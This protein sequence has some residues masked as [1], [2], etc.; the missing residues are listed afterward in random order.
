VKSAALYKLG[1]VKGL[2]WFPHVI[3]LASQ[4]DH[5]APFDSAHVRLNGENN[6]GSTHLVQQKMARHILKQLRGCRTVTRADV[7]FRIEE[8]GIDALIGRTAHI[9]LIESESLIEML[10]HKYTEVFC[11]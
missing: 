6:T 10:L 7:N 5:Y 1:K 2:G 8:G 11:E 4:Q 3:F 9:L